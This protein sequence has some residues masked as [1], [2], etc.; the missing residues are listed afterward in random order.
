MSQAVAER[1]LFVE[2]RSDLYRLLASLLLAPPTAE[3]VRALGDPD[4]EALVH[5]IGGPAASTALRSL[6]PTQE[7]ETLRR[8]YF[9]L[10]AVPTSRYAAP[11]ESVYC[12]DREIDGEKVS[13]LLGGPSTDAVR[14][15]YVQNGFELALPELPDHV[16]CEMAF[17]AALGQQETLALRAGDVR[18]A[19]EV[20]HAAAEFVCAH[21]LRWVGRLAQRLGEDER[22]QLYPAVVAL[23]DA[24]LR[25]QVGA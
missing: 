3:A 4:T 19:D 6:G 10:L 18:R 14:R 9:D 1:V 23:A 5:A 2:V 20:R 11:F 15:A 17:V 25:S 12:D 16:G 22:A 24:M 13:G 21:P 7:P 8:E